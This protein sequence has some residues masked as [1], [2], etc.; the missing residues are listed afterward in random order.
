MKAKYC[1][2]IIYKDIYCNRLFQYLRFIYKTE[3]IKEGCTS[4][5]ASLFCYRP[6]VVQLLLVFHSSKNERGKKSKSGT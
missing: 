5:C 2:I 4:T 6:S 1:Y 3:E